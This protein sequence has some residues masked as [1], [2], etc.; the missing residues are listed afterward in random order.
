MEIQ[1]IEQI[2]S[3]RVLANASNPVEGTESVSVTCDAS[4]LIHS[5]VWFKD[6]QALESNER[7]L[8]SPNNDTLTIKLVNRRDTGDY[9][10]LVQNPVSNATATFN[11]EVVYGPD[12]SSIIPPG[13]VTAFLGQTIILYCSATSSPAAE[14]KWYRGNTV[15]QA[16][17]AHTIANITWN[18]SGNYTCLAHNKVTDN[19]IYTSVD[20]IVTDSVGAQ[21]QSA[22]I[23]AITLGVIL[24]VIIILLIAVVVYRQCGHSAGDPGISS[25]RNEARTIYQN[26]SFHMGN[27]DN[28]VPD[29]PYERIGPQSS[30]DSNLTVAAPKV[31]KNINN[32]QR[33]K[34]KRLPPEPDADASTSGG[35]DHEGEDAIRQ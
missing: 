31:Y 25:T 20:F 22:T 17:P 2:S 10:C 21:D 5:R 30:E 14:Y 19:F 24:F 15:L 32:V 6:K 28:E 3:V 16:G 1:V 33:A 29:R 4:G 7:I 23:A 27:Q 12:D 18:Q 35:Q 11:I 9:C 8:M 13:P 26:E 34:N